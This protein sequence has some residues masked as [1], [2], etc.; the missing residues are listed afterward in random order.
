[1]AKKTKR[2]SNIKCSKGKLYQRVWVEM[3]PKERVQTHVIHHAPTP[4]PKRKAPK[5]KHKRK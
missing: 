3:V 4:A 5:R 1:M 2:S